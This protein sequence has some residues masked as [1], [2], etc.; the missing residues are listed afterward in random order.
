[1]PD[2][3]DPTVTT[4]PTTVWNKDVTVDLKALFR[5]VAKAAAHAAS[6]KWSD[7]VIDSGELLTA[8]GIK[9]EPGELA[10]LLV[11]RSLLGAM[12][13]L[14]KENAATLQ[15]GTEEVEVEF[16]AKIA[17]AM[18]AA[19]A[20]IDSAFLNDP[21][22][23]PLVGAVQVS[24]GQWLE[25]HGIASTIAEVI[26]SRLGSHFVYELNQEWVRNNRLYEPLR[27][28]T[29]TPFTRAG[30]R[31]MAWS[32]Y[33]AH[34]VR[35][36]DESLFDEPFSLRQ[37]Y[38]PLRA[39]HLDEP[40]GLTR[41]EQKQRRVVV[42][43][44]GALDQWLAD[45]PRDDAVRIISG[46]PGSGKSS[47]AKMYAARLAQK[48]SRRFVF[49]PL[50]QFDPAGDL[51]TSVGE[52][53]RATGILPYNPLG[54]GGD[55]S[56]LLIFDGLDELAMQGKVATDVALAF[57]RE[58]QRQT[59]L[60]NH[61]YSRLFA[62]I[63]GREVVVQATAVDF[64]KRGRCCTCCRTT[65]PIVARLDTSTHRTCWRWTNATS[66]GKSTVRSPLVTSRGCRR[67]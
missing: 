40:P 35:Q 10:W 27:A 39:Y 52:F 32:L 45:E 34:L 44:A 22:S 24:F 41:Q 50:H 3:G 28:A 61:S 49:V 57:V 36:V 58:V 66:G 48:S 15:I 2:K 25:A 11:S 63:T 54:E 9:P 53:V 17:E 30:E 8:A 42:D 29:T 64:R 1:M 21:L 5:A 18:K 59:G 43:L 12:F 37:I 7:V 13:S 16:G 65:S 47:F 31:E 14:V 20:H 19:P 62:I 4:Q 23:L 60:R 38:V 46:G 56:L 6:G 67:R 55:N 33:R 51:V 26:A